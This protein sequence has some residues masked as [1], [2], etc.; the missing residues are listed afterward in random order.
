MTTFQRVWE[1]AVRDHGD[2]P[3]LVF[4]AESGV[5]SDWSYAEFDAVVA[6]TAGALHAAGVRSGSA[7]HVVLRNC[8]AF[9]ALWL[10]ASRLGAWL[11]PVDPQSTARDIASQVRRVAP[12]A[13]IC[14]A[15]RGAPYREGAA[16]RVPA[17][18]ELAEDAADTAAGGPLDGPVFAPAVV[19]PD[20]RLAVMFT[21]GTTS[22]PKG[23]VLTQAAYATVA[24]VMAEAVA[25][26]P[27]HRWHVTLP[28]FHA[29]AQY[30][31]FAPAMAAG[32]SVALSAV[33]S[34][35]G[36]VRHARELGV[37]HASLFAAPIRMILARVPADERPLA[38][39]HVWFAQSLGREHHRKFADLVGARP[40]QLYGM[41]E[42][43]AIVC[44][45]TGEL[46]RHDVIGQPVAGRRIRLEQAGTGGPADAPG[47]LLVLGTPGVD[48]FAGYLDDE[49]LTAKVFREKTADGTW[50]ATG[51]LVSRGTDGLL[52]F[53]GRVDDVI[54]VAGENVSLTEVEAVLAQAPGV[55]EVAVV[56][57]ED[58]VRDVVPV[59]Y[60]VARDAAA[61]PSPA[62]LDEW[63]ARNLTPAA[64]PRDWTLIDELPRTSVG[65][66][67][68][69]RLVT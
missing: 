33:F 7:V 54:K 24:R 47:E 52:R 61:P 60:V 22:A 5:R 46:A 51:D 4:R 2:R 35:S 27:R 65:K 34:A 17:V 9:V 10:A 8:P 12:A 18:I 63:A 38:L 42:T 58:A 1:S 11:V 59:A 28:L 37:T 3:F 50:F 64:R 49:A 26:E 14:A 6:R 66:V 31:C 39:E 20:D 41:T 29:N 15:S 67:R 53:V 19:R 40:R 30:Y 32:A 43:V 69:F 36:W 57:R 25:L 62:E 55:L 44:A 16:G 68:R 56:S 13:G 48:L 23:V 21:S 45:D